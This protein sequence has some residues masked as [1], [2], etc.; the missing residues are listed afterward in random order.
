MI[1]RFGADLVLGVHLLFIVYALLGGLLIRWWPRS[2]WVHLPAL[3]WAILV[4]AAGWP[5]PL[6]GLEL[7]LLERCGEAGY[8]GGF[9][10]HYLL[11]AIY[12]DG[13][14]RQIQWVL[15]GI[16]AVT[17]IIIYGWVLS[18]RSSVVSQK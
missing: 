11:A 17:N 15:A 5:C 13:L 8:S 6:T 4:E 2:I 3:A 14:T 18:R 7:F 12:P 9:I 16:V 1:Y 10:S